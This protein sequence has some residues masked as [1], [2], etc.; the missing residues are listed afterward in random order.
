L[1]KLFE[2]KEEQFQEYQQQ[3][4]SVAEAVQFFEGIN[5]VAL[6]Y[7]LKPISRIV[8]EP[9]RFVVGKE[10][11]PQQEF[12]NT[13]SAKIVVAGSYFDIIDFLSEIFVRRQKVSISNLRIALPP[14]EDFYPKASFEISLITDLSKD[15]KK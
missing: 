7:N 12:L 10:T 4:F 3:C 9:K 2:E 6:T 11:K 13:Q 14:G 1:G 8:S 5:A 15:A